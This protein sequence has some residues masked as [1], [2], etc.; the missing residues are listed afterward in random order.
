MITLPGRPTSAEL[1]D[2]LA[3]DAR[4]V[5][6][7]FSRGKDS[8]AV[9]IEL[10]RRGI[11][12]IPV[13]RAVVPGLKF[14]RDDLDRYEQYFGTH[15]IDVPSYGFYRMLRN[16]VYQPPQRCAVI[17]AAAF[18][19]VGRDDFDDLIR[20]VYA[21]PDTWIVDGVRASDSATRLMAMKKY[22]PIKT[23]ARRQSVL[24]DWQRAE[25][26]NVINKA[27]LT[28]GPDYEMCGRSFDSLRYVWISQI[29]DRYP[30]DWE[31]IRFW[32]PLIDLEIM[33]VE[34]MHVE[35]A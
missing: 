19:D 34:E 28:L 1:L 33:R 30:Q 7:N 13:H 6:L 29:R 9:W 3:A 16:L 31:T 24:W 8:L 4:P 14:V 10:H 23:Q 18:P 26:M 25:V 12:V 17:E 35:A 20:T 2:R 32:F 15:I 21:D 5:V 22:G 11:P 27:G